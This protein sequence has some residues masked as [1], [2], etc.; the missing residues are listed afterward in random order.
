VGTTSASSVSRS[1]VRGVMQNDIEEG[2]VYF[3]FPVV[4]NETECPEP[5]HKETDTRAGRAYHLHKSLLTDG[6]LCGRPWRRCQ[7]A[8]QQCHRGCAESRAGAA[9]FHILSAPA[10][11]TAAR[12]DA[13]TRPSKQEIA[14]Y[15]RRELLPYSD[16]SSQDS[17]P[18][19]SRLLTFHRSRA[20]AENSGTE[21]P[22]N[23]L[24]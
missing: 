13:T 22:I 15:M 9:C 21:L 19:C 4:V 17:M 2:T 10:I 8:G 14:Q 3:Q 11:A 1:V 7:R 12:R 18:V 6:R 20:M 24:C 23:A 5:V 16:V